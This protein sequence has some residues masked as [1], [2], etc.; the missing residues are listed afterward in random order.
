MQAAHTSA[1]VRQAIWAATARS[2]WMSVCL[3]LVTT[4]QHVPIIWVDT[5]VRYEITQT[6]LY[7]TE[8][9]AMSAEYRNAH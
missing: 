2:R 4:V 9:L 3:T 6:D 1:A 8:L 7:I 5:H